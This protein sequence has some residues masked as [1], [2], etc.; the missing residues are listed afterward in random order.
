MTE[1]T[2]ATPKKNLDIDFGCAALREHR[3]EATVER[4][5]LEKQ[6]QVAQTW[7]KVR[8][9]DAATA[10]FKYARVTPG[11]NGEPPQMAATAAE[12]EVARCDLRV[13]EIE[14][15]MASLKEDELR[16]KLRDAWRKEEDEMQKQLVTQ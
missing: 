13:K 10:R 2:G 3:L 1:A 7:S 9:V 14:L 15:K 5:L 6:L 12:I 16:V 8:N 4:E 11:E